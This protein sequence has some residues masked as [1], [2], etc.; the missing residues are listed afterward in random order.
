MASWIASFAGEP[1]GSLRVTRGGNTCYV[2]VWGINTEGEESLVL[3]ENTDGLEHLA[4]KL[5]ISS[6]MAPAAASRYATSTLAALVGLGHS[7]TER[8]SGYSHQVS[9]SCFFTI[10][11][12]TDRVS[13]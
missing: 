5:G 11:A 3:E 2:A 13:T 6:R 4:T 8:V 12:R 10:P 9:A 7:T 1:I